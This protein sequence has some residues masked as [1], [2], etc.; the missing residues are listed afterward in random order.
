M[1]IRWKLLIVMLAMILVPLVLL[2]WN[3]QNSMQAMGTDLAATASNA[4]IQKAKEELQIIVEEHSTVLRRERQ[5]IE[6]IIKLQ[7]SEL[8]RWIAGNNGAGISPALMDQ[9]T[10]PEHMPA[11][12]YKLM[13]NGQRRAFNLHYDHV[14]QR[15]GNGRGVTG[16]RLE[17]M[18]PLFRQL[19][20]KHP[21]L[22]FWQL[23]V[24]ENGPQTIY[25]G[26]DHWPMR[27]RPTQTDWYRAAK[28]TAGIVW[29]RPAPDPFTNRLQLTV[30]K[31]L[32][33][34]EGQLAGITAIRVP[35]GE[36]LEND[37]HFDYVSKQ[38]KALLV[39]S[40]LSM[41]N[42]RNGIRI[43]AAPQKGTGSRR[44]WWQPTSNEWIDVGNDQVLNRFANDIAS[45]RSAV[46]DI[47]YGAVDSLMAYSNI[48]EQGTALVLIVPK[49]DIMAD[50]LSMEDS[51]LDRIDRQIRFTGF[52]VGAVMVVVV[53]MAFFLSQSITGNIGKLVAASRRIANGDFSTRAAI[54]ANDEMGELGRAFDRMVPDLQDGMKRKHALDLAMEV[55]QNLLP[56]ETP[57][58][59]GLQ[60]AA[61]SIYCDET[62]GD[63]FDFPSLSFDQKDKLGIIVGDVAGH[64]ISA[65]LLMATVRALLRSRINQPGHLAK[66]I[67]DVNELLSTDTDTGGQFVTLFAALIDRSRATL[68]WIRAGHDPALLY[69]P[70]EDEFTELKGKGL[71]LGVDADASY[72]INQISGLSPGQILCIAT[73]GI[74][75]SN[76]PQ[77]QM[78]GRQRLQTIIRDKRH[79]AASQIV[80]EVL[81]TVT[82]YRAE[83]RQADD[84]TIVII[85]IKE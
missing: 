28:S 76:N 10:S 80:D 74:W 26:V 22:V 44:R 41:Q 18:L 6:M 29:G 77:G 56:S 49:K 61:R 54:N 35:V 58:I 73:D 53:A 50:A 63:F 20:L 84:L 37:R 4:L 60:V 7:A 81:D 68:E 5:L 45:N 85:K 11:K 39:D 72:Q 70:S 14:S 67:G 75:E 32:Q 57:Q 8:E 25:P 9:T 34:P 1:R 19:A 23:T 55:Q 2:R 51:V 27:F 78:F 46:L 40:R 33:G 66:V 31:R 3:A 21:D 52:L 64:G 38:V 62:G 16:K 71:A 69:D 24:F 17:D 82:V 79:L 12:R 48:D 47:I 83:A 43:I 15:L 42:G 13:G 59:E 65:A 36:L 30:A